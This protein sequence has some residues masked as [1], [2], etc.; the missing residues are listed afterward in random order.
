MDAGHFFYDES[1]NL[2]DGLRYL[3]NNIR[4]MR[5]SVTLD[6]LLP[7]T[8]QAILSA[9]LLQPQRWWYLSELAN[10]L[11]VSPSSLQRELSS[12]VEAEILGQRLNGNRVYY[13]P[14]PD[15]PFLPEL[16]GLLIKTVGLV[17]VLKQALKPV[18]NKIDVAFVFG[19]FATASEL[20]DSD[21]DLMLVGDLGLADIA[22]ALK[23]SEQQLQRT[24]NPVVFRPAEVME[25]L[26]AKNHFLE[27]VR[28]SNKIFLLGSDN[29]LVKALSAK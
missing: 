3:R 26:K 29:D 18:A 17:G 27:T 21:V 25:K 15:C 12:L 8:R 13:R 10:F 6:A 20:A 24:I 22:T 2:I 19:S 23:K 14:N 4:Y 28:K 9:T 16:Q 11:K 7:K 1:R 5:K